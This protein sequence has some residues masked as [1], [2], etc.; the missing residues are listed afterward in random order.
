MFRE[1]VQQTTDDR[2]LL[3]GNICWKHPDGRVFDGEWRNG[4]PHGKMTVTA[5]DGSRMSANFFQGVAQGYMVYDNANGFHTEGECSNGKQNGAGHAR[6]PDGCTYE[7]NFAD[8]LRSGRVPCVIPTAL[9]MK[10]TG[11]EINA[12]A[13]E[14]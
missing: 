1:I 12:A 13:R 8:G 14:P 4:L 2:E 7:G 3:N 10:A 5:P 9:S 11:M 6:W